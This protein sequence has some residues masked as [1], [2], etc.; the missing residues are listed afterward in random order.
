[1]ADTDETDPVRF[2]DGF[3]EEYELAYGGNWESAMEQQGATLDALIRDL[4][5]EARAALDCSCGIGTQAIG[6]ARCGYRVVGTDISS[7]EIDRARREAQRL[8]VNASFSV[9]DFRDLSG[10]EGEFDVVISCDNAIPHLLNESDVRRALEQ[11]LSKLRAGGLVVITMRDFD[12]ALAEKP[13]IA[14]PV[15]VPGSPRRVLVRLHDWYADEP[16][17]TVR[18]LVLTEADGGWLV[19]EHTTRYR[20]ITRAELAAAATAA[21]FESIDW[22]TDRAL[23]GDQQVMTARRP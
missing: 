7:A 2:Y 8:A 6:L 3:A 15:V 17:Y 14:P 22:P 9:A 12:R 16:F 10:V 13:S 5:P 1:M 19:K 11:M 21:G 4:L 18:F 23:I 20:A